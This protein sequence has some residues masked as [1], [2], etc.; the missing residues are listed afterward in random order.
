MRTVSC[1]PEGNILKATG[2]PEALYKQVLFGYVG[3]PVIFLYWGA[4]YTPAIYPQ[5]II[6]SWRRYFGFPPNPHPEAVCLC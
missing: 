3:F 5:E 4:T 6:L 2:P 1:I